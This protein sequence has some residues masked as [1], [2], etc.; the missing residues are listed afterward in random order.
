MSYS[1]QPHGL[2]H[3]RLPCPSPTPRACSNS[4]PLSQWCHPNISSSVVPFS[5]LQSFQHQ[6]LFQWVGSLHQVAQVLEF[7]LQHESFQWIFRA[8]FLE[9]WLVSFPCSPGD[10]QESSTAPQFKSINSS[11]F[12][13]LHSPT[14]YPYMTT[15]KT[16][17]LTRQTFVGKV[18]SLLLNM[19][20]KLVLMFLWVFSGVQMFPQCQIRSD[21]RT[22]FH[23]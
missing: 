5:C 4:C 17:A 10:S 21:L 20:S 1:M 9:D 14:L 22:A 12:S 8:D 6:G 3:A 7:Q 16:I 15:G 19:P 11:V 13:L 2:Q 23:L 18:M